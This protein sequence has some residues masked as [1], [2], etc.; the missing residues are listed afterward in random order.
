M[1]AVLAAMDARLFAICGEELGLDPSGFE[2]GQPIPGV[3]IAQLFRV[4]VRVTTRDPEAAYLYSVMENEST[5]ASHPAH[6]YFHDRQQAALETYASTVP[7][8]FGD[9]I[10]IAR[11]AMGLLSGLHIQWLRDL[12]GIDMV[13][14]WEQVARGIPALAA[15][16]PHD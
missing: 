10:L 13:A 7:E 8:G 15:G 12:H 14:L 16:G 5:D 11:M 4:T 9:P 3:T 1:E 2:L 6:D